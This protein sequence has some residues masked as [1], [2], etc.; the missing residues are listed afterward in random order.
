MVSG[1]LGH[2]HHLIAMREMSDKKCQLRKK[3]EGCFPFF[4]IGKSVHCHCKLRSE[5]GQILFNKGGIPGV[6]VKDFSR[7]HRQKTRLK[8]AACLEL[9]FFQLVKQLVNVDFLFALLQLILY[10]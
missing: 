4:R 3:E 2:Q 7:R 6:E 9:I 5:H 10:I 8:Q 1:E